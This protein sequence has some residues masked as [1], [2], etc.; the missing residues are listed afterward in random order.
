MEDKAWGITANNLYAIRFRIEKLLAS[1]GRDLFRQRIGAE[2]DA[3]NL[4]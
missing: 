1:K 3:E 4:P 2:Q